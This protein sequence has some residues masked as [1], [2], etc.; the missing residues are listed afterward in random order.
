MAYTGQD[1]VAQLR[2][3]L[4]E[5]SAASG[6]WRDSDLLTWINKGMT[7]VMLKIR[8]Q[9]SHWFDRVVTT[10]DSA[11]TIKGET[12]TPS[13]ALICTSGASTLTLPPDC[14]EVVSLMPTDQTLLDRGVSFRYMP[15]NSPEYVRAQRLSTTYIT[16]TWQYLYDIR[17]KTTVQVAPAF[18]ETFDVRLQYVGLPEF[19][20]LLDTLPTMFD[21]MTDAAVLY[22]A[23]RALKA[24]SSTEY[25]RAF[26]AY[27]E[28]L[29]D[30]LSLTRPRS[31]Q[32]PEVVTGAWDDYDSTLST[33]YGNVA[34]S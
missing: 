32:T 26:Q 30:L 15:F 16:G 18:L 33:T 1:L 20:S 17:S 9:R 10:D 11:S 34:S 14:I 31:S 27:K 5:F 19:M 28:E 3:D 23:Y 7:R 2:A 13:T 4:D 6:Q 12:Y 24:V 8:E 21:E 25:Q 22:A 29:N